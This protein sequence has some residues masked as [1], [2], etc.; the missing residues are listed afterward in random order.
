MQLPHD[1]FFYLYDAVA[2][3]M[4][5]IG[6]GTVSYCIRQ[7]IPPHFLYVQRRMPVVCQEICDAKR[8]E[9]PFKMTNCGNKLDV[10][11]IL[12]ANHFKLLLSHIQKCI[13]TYR[14]SFTGNRSFS[15][16]F[17][18]IRNTHSPRCS[19]PRP[20]SVGATLPAQLSCMWKTICDAT[21][22]IQWYFRKSWCVLIE[23]LRMEFG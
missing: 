6:C 12:E 1:R 3:Y 15:P 2:S 14:F 11:S 7:Y 13:V 4:S 8:P 9:N 18:I 5:N 17:S 20:C 16:Y 22:L 19:I 23:K 21:G 10:S